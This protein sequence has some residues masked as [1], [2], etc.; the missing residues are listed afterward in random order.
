LSDAEKFREFARD[1][2]RIAETMKGEDK[3]TL[4]DIAK[5]WEERARAVEAKN[6]S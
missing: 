4:R 1:C 5:A 6:K 3:E 2:L